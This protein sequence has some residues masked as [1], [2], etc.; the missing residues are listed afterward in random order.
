MREEELR[1]Q[2]E[3]ERKQKEDERKQKDFEREMRLLDRRAQVEASGHTVPPEK[4]VKPRYKFPSFNEKVDKLDTFLVLYEKQAL[5]NK[6]PKK[7]WPKHL[8]PLLSGKARDVFKE[9]SEETCSDYDRLKNALLE[10]Y[11]LTSDGYRKKFFSGSPEKDETFPA[12]VAR[13][14]SDF[15]KWIELSET[16]K[17]F[18][19]LYDLV[20]R[21]RVFDSCSPQLVAFLKERNPQTMTEVVSLAKN[22]KEA[23]PDNTIC[24]EPVSLPF[25]ATAVGSNNQDR[26]RN[27]SKTRNTSWNR[28]RHQSTSPRRF[29]R[30]NSGWQET[31]NQSQNRSFGQNSYGGQRNQLS[32]QNQNRSVN[33]NRSSVRCW[34]CNGM[35]HVQS[36]CPLMRH[37]NACSVVGKWPR[38]VELQNA[39]P[40]IPGLF[41]SQA[42][43]QTSLTLKD[44]MFDGF[45][46]DKPIVYLKDSGAE[47]AGV[48]RKHVPLSSLTGSTIQC[49]TFG[50]RIETFDEAL[51]DINTPHFKG[52]ARACVLNDS[53]A[54]VVLGNIP[55]LVEVDKEE[56]HY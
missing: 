50:G 20:M 24:K 51:I 17:T 13:L 29:G 43:A 53:C 30:S 11:N 42:A 7:D 25:V 10:R 32:N 35:G 5:S 36:S 44:Y 26:G 16:E 23:H 9:A 54:D 45:L 55:G 6:I 21:H 2:K 22:Y 40:R 27:R 56:I 1:R 34:N 14:D 4:D 18:E 47:V 19:R 3:D 41:F 52:I 46:G 15:T 31:R 28:S 49:M 39:F 8:I 12:F 33:Q 48:H 38:G 37:A